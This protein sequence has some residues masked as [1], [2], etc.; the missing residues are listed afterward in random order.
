MKQLVAAVVTV[1]AVVAGLVLAVSLTSSA[2]EDGPAG[3]VTTTTVEDV[4]DNSPGDDDSQQ[5]D[6]DEGD[7]REPF[8]GRFSFRFG[9]EVPAELQE[10]LD[11]L[12]ELGIEVPEPGDGRF[13]FDLTDE[14][15]PDIREALETCGFGSFGLDRFDGEIPFPDALRGLPR[16]HFGFGFGEEARDELAA[17]LAELGSFE[18]TDAV[19][20]KLDECLP[21][22]PTFEAL[23]GE[24]DE[25]R[26]WFEG[27]EFGDGFFGFRHGPGELFDFDFDFDFRPEGLGEDPSGGAASF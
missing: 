19:R 1:V 12:A 6:L 24:L 9:G 26:E 21:E 3:E 4:Q 18:S 11:C 20:E 16:G 13:G 25:L 7:E 17:C 23:E 15:L 10:R 14:D 8:A 5:D 2:Q 27:R 22:P